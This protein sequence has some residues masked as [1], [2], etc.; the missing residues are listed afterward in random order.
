MSDRVIFLDRDGVINEDSDSYIKSTEEWIPIPGSLEAI[1]R[2]SG[3]G[4]RI[5]IVSNQSGL[6]R[7]L[8]DLSTLGRMHQKLRDLLAKQG[9]RVEMI[10]FCPHHPDQGCECRK[11]QPGLLKS[12]AQRLGIDLKGVPF[13]GDSLTDIQAARFFGMEPWLVKTGKGSGL[14]KS[15]TE[16]LQGVK[17]AA[18]LRSVAEELIR[19]GS[20]T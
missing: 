9:G 18:D 11:P 6:S 16:G 13:V 5:A 1:A 20:T 10:A 2:L 4:F 14:V 7:G 19:T 8:F 15:A 12:A 3:A 17:V